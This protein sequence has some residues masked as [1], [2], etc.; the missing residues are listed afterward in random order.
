MREYEKYPMTE[1]SGCIHPDCIYRNHTE[2]AT[3]NCS[4]LAVTGKSRIKGLP[5]RL[6]L[7]CNCP[8][9][10]PNGTKKEVVIKNDWVTKARELYSAGATDREIA[11]ELG[12]TRSTV[13]AW[14]RRNYLP[15]HRD[16][17]GYI[18]KYD[19]NLG[20]ALW[21]AGATDREIMEALGCKRNT[22]CTWRDRHG[23]P[24]NA[25]RRKNHADV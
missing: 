2:H 3:G 24:V 5:A 20:M 23:L 14:R 22:V 13:C 19:W 9:Y 4:Y 7:P 11:K 10:V 16:K 17:R 18:E 15:L 21:R 12:L 25:G 6:Q 8:R 1:T